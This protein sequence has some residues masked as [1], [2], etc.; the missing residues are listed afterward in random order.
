MSLVHY[1]KSNSIPSITLTPGHVLQSEKLTT[2]SW[3]QLQRAS[4]APHQRQH[5]EEQVLHLTWATWLNR[6]WWWRIDKPALRLGEWERWPRPSKAAALGKMEPAHWPGSTMELAL[7]AWLL[8]S[9]PQEHESKELESGSCL[10]LIV[11]LSS[12]SRAVL[13]SL[14]WWNG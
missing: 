5:L 8:L 7:K 9:H 3:T 6:P 1:L 14:P 12:L 11:S 10:L 4:P 13:E 2:G